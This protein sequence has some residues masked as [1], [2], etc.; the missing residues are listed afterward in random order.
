MSV[1]FRI[2]VSVVGESMAIKCKV[3]QSIGKALTQQCK[4]QRELPKEQWDRRNTAH[5]LQKHRWCSRVKV[6][7]AAEANTYKL[8]GMENK[9]KSY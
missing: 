2:Q 6:E 1:L 4:A 7:P 8:K 3:A 5:T 9:A